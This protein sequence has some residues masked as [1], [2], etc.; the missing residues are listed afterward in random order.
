MKKLVLIT[1]M[2]IGIAFLASSVHAQT[3]QSPDKATKDQTT[4]TDQKTKCKFVDKDGDGVC[5]YSKKCDNQEKCC[6]KGMKKGE[7]PGMNPKNCCGKGHQHR[8]GFRKCTHKNH[9]KPE[10]K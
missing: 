1:G 6:K 9:S 2:I 4:Q 10:K 3:S 7:C 5:D 8:H